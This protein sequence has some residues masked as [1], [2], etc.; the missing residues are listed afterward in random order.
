MYWPGKNYK[1]NEAILKKRAEKIDAQHAA[2]LGS[3]RSA[4]VAA[5]I[6]SV[7]EGDGDSLVITY[8]T[9]MSHKQGRIV[10]KGTDFGPYIDN[11]EKEW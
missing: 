9:G 8:T 10:I 4:L 5:M 1:A 7:D 3:L 2:W 11:N 6:L